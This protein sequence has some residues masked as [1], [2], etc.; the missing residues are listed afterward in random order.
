M[1]RLTSLNLSIII[2][3][4]FYCVMHCLNMNCVTICSAKCLDIVT[5][6][7]LPTSCFRYNSEEESTKS[8]NSKMKLN[9]KLIRVS[10]RKFLNRMFTEFRENDRF[11]MIFLFIYLEKLTHLFQSFTNSLLL[12]NALVMLTNAGSIACKCFK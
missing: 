7:N 2:V 12:L 9:Q 5:F 10:L 6:K 8:P 11:L 1:T 4:N 3:N